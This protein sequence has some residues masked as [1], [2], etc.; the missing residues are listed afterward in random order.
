MLDRNPAVGVKLPRKRAVKPT[1][2]LSLAD[3]RRMIEGVKEPTKSLITLIVFASMRPGEVLA[4]HFSQA[5]ISSRFALVDESLPVYFGS[6]GGRSFWFR[7]EHRL[8]GACGA[9]FLV[10]PPA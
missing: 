4:L 2:L 6:G 3:I 7:D 5:L 10:A 1:V 9:I 8:F